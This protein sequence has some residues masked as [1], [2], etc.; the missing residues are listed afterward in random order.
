MPTGLLKPRQQAFVDAYLRNGGNATKAAKEAGYKESSAPR[1]GTILLHND[2]IKAYLMKIQKR[3]ADRTSLDAEKI[4]EELAAN[5]Y[6]AREQN[7]IAASNQALQLIG[8]H[9]GMF[10]EKTHSVHEIA[11]LTNEERLKR[12][13]QFLESGGVAGTR[14][15]P[16][17]DE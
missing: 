3:A 2:A 9:L 14:R 6:I 5:A 4:L 16:A 8:K 1:M 11:A 17:G 13:A 10:V 12:L 7:Q 15:A